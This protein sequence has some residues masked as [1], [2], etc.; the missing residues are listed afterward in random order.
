MIRN[1]MKKMLAAAT[2]SLVP[3]GLA[4]MPM[5]AA[6]QTAP[7]FAQCQVCHTVNKGG[8]NGV[9]PNLNGIFTRAPAS[10]PGFNY[11]PAFRKA[12]LKWDDKTLAEFLAAPQKKVPGT[13]MTIAVADPA[14]RAAIIAYLKSE[15]AK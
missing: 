1:A 13:R 15:A 2:A 8:R 12:L 6:A 10:A 3:A 7:V 5:P 9:G 4:L 14:K 11:S